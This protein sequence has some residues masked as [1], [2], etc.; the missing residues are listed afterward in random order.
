MDGEG[1]AFLPSLLGSQRRAGLH[2]AEV[3][4]EGQDVSLGCPFAESG[5]KDRACSRRQA[6][7][8]VGVWAS[9][10]P[11]P[12]RQQKRR[13]A[14]NRGETAGA[15]NEEAPPLDDPSGASSWKAQA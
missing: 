12:A 5:I 13:E 8:Q 7:R 11:C 15:R 4:G 2:M 3:Q 9:R 10:S 6:P 14:Q 1:M